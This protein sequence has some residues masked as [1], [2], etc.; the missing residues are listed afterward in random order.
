MKRSGHMLLKAGIGTI[1]HNQCNEEESTSKWFLI[2]IS[3]ADNLMLLFVQLSW[4]TFTKLSPAAELGSAPLA[5]LRPLTQ[6]S[7]VR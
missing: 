6:S 7:S 4:Y 1:L 2:L 5:F 3:I